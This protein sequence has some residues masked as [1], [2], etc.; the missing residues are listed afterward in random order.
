MKP[1][2]ILGAARR[3]I[4]KL[5]HQRIKQ[6]QP[7]PSMLVVKIR[8]DPGLDLPTHRQS[9][10]AA[11]DRPQAFPILALEN[12]PLVPPASNHPF[13]HHP[14]SGPP[15]PERRTRQG[16]QTPRNKTTGNKTTSK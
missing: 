9:D 14:A 10:L 7:P 12:H 3:V 1:N 13:L 11:P 2:Q 5:V 6:G 8:S 16:P 15:P 4:F